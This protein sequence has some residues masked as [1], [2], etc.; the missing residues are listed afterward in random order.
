MNTHALHP[1]AHTRENAEEISEK[2]EQKS[3]FQKNASASDRC[4]MNFNG[5]KNELVLLMAKLSLESGF[6]FRFAYMSPYF[7]EGLLPS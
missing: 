2:P 3:G 6:P 4:F 1:K 7:E 5:E